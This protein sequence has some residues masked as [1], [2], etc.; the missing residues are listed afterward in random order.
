M[1]AIQAT[2]NKSTGPR[3]SPRKQKKSQ[4]TAPVSPQKL[5]PE[6]PDNAIPKTPERIDT[7]DV[8]QVPG[9]PF[10]KFTGSPSKS[11]EECAKRKRGENKTKKDSDSDSDS[12]EPRKRLT[13]K[14]KKSCI[15][16]TSD[17]PSSS[18]EDLE[19]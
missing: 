7:S 15:Q 9:T 17:E 18:S 10:Y 14:A 13:K 2:V 5:A 6:V 16:E 11:R 1:E 4:I 3:R 12:S 19:E 8:S